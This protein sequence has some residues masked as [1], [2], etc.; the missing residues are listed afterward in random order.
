MFR[1]WSF[2]RS[3]TVFHFVF[4]FFFVLSYDYLK[5]TDENSNEIGKYCGTQFTGSEAF[6]GGKQA[7]LTFHSDRSHQRRGF[8]LKFTTISPSK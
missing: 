3:L 8:V 4:V 2:I 5:I 1:K 7:L 6:V